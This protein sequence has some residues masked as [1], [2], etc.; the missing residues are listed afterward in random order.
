MSFNTEEKSLTPAAL[1]TMLN[2][3][4]GE[5]PL[6]SFTYVEDVDGHVEQFGEEMRGAFI[7]L[8]PV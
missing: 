3:L 1:E 7:I 8:A 5:K 2:K 6:R 4:F